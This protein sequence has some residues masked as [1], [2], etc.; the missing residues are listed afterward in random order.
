MVGHRGHHG[1]QTDR[2]HQTQAA[3][4]KHEH[5]RFHDH[6]ADNAAV[7]RPKGL[8]HPD[9]FGALFDANGQDVCHAHS[10]GEQRHQPNAPDEQ[11]DAFKDG[12]IHGV[13]LVVV[14]D[15]NPRLSS[16]WTAFTSFNHESM[17]P[18]WAMVASVSMS[19]VL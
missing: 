11:A 18:L 10:A 13:F 14:V 19:P 15:T 3:T 7:G 12:S 17:R 1:E 2:Q 6:K 9:F 5:G 8:A 16:G 4:D